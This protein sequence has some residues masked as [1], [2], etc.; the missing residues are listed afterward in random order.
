MNPTLQT[1][2][3][4]LLVFLSHGAYSQERAVSGMDGPLSQSDLE[5][6]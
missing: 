4:F 3:L 5:G 2:S 6:F 1:L